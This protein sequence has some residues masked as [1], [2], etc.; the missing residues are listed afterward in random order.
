[1]IA[2]DHIWGIV[3]AGGEGKRLQ[4]YIKEKYGFVRPKQYSAIIGNRT[5]L[6]HTL[7]RVEKMIPPKQIKIVINRSHEP[8]LK[9]NIKDREKR[10]LIFTPSNRESAASIYFALSKIY[11]QDSESICTIFPSDHFVGHE[12]RFLDYVE[13]AISF[14]EKYPNNVAV[15][16]IKPADANSQYGWIQ[17]SHNF[18]LHEENRFYKVM[19]FVEKPDNKLALIYFNNGW[20]WNSLVVVAKSEMLLK[21][22]RKHLT[23]IYEAFKKARLFYGTSE[24]DEFVKAVFEK[25]PARNFS[26]SVLE[27]ESDSMYVL[28]VEGVFW[29]DW[30]N[31]EQ[32]IKD[33]ETLGIIS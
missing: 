14:V 33:L 12:D 15:L 22:Y 2:T 30:G 26:K 31:K 25:I 27:K 16:G 1:M 17:P 18:V 21:M 32:V 13:K 6:R 4:D 19:K 28:K 3:L 5:M 23:P 7:D 24:E 9:G 29:S 20:L 11:Y 8:Y 10:S